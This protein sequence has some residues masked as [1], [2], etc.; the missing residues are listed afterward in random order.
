MKIGLFTSGYQRNPLE[1]AFI[2]AKRFGYDYIELWGGRPH[3][4][5]PDLKN[6]DIKIVRSLMEKYEV[7]I[8]G[9]TPEHNAYPYNFMLGS[10]AMRRDCVEYLKLCMDMGKEMGAGFTMISPAHAGYGTRYDEMWLRLTTTVREL[11]D[12]AEKIQH[13]IVVEALTPYETNV[14][15]SANDLARLFDLV[16]SPYI[17]GMCDIVPP[18][19]QG[20]S[21]M[22][23]FDL[24]KDK[25]R[26]MHIIDGKNGDDTHYLPGEGDIPLVQLLSEIESYGYKGTATIELVT[27]YINEPRLY[28]KRAIDNLRA[29]MEGR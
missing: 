6:G 21:I 20:E 19:I 17:V 7:Q 23:Y 15:K 9:Y 5:A 12:Y 4:F 22:A 18:F 8:I 25:M 1:H 2:D 3:A 27:N 13:T 28:A 14:V 11:A 16:D 29:A 24:L 26:H 10:E